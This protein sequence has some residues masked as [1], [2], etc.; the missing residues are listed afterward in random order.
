HDETATAALLAD[1][2][3][4][5]DVL[6][7][8]AEPGEE[9]TPAPA[10]LDGDD[11]VEMAYAVERFDANNFALAVNNPTG[12]PAWLLFSDVW[13]QGWR[14][15]VD[16]RE[17]PVRRAALAYKAVQV[18]PGRSR[19]HFHFHIPTVSVL[20]VLIGLCSLGW[21]GFLIALAGRLCRGRDEP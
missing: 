16:G 7:L 5:G 10:R 12:A 18:P 1:P 8:S 20:Y 11:R 15:A 21:L 13:H 9:E 17:V 2:R 6:F 3:Y 14:A 19:V 4:R